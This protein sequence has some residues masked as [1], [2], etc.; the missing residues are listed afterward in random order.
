M[1]RRA[2][3]TLCALALA[4]TPPALARLPQTEPGHLR[5][6]VLRDVDN[7]NPLLSTQAASSDIAQLVFSGLIRYDDRGEA[8]PDAAEAVPTRRNGGIS[9]DG[10]T[11]TYHLRRNVV[12]SDG[13]PLTANDVVFTW[14]AVLNP[15]NNVPNHF[16]YDLAQSVVAKDRF[17]VVAHLREPNA[18]FV[19]FFMRCGTQGAILPEHLL[20]AKHDLNQDPYNRQPVGSGPFVVTSYQPGSSIELARNPRW[21]GAK[22]PALDR[23]S[24]R[25]IPNENSLLVA[26]RTHEIDF[27]FAAPEQ[28]YRELQALGGVHVSAQPFMSYEAVVF[29]TRRAPFDDVRVRRA[30]AAAIDWDA[31][32]RNVY[33]AVDLPGVTDVFPRSWAFDPSVKP[34]P[35][36]LARA[37]AFLDAAGWHPGSDGIRTRNGQRLTVTMRTVTGVI[38]R[39]NA[40]VQI[41]QQ[42]RL[43]GFDVQVVNAPAN[44]LFAPA[45]GGGV[46]AKGDFDAAI[47]GWTEAPDPADDEQTIGPDRVPPYGA[48]FSG[49]RDPEIG[50]LQREGASSYEPARR[51][52]A[53]VALQRREHEMVPFETIVW[54]ANIDAISD[55]FHGF[56]PAV[57]VSDFWNPWD[58]SI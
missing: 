16:P 43:V 22:K 21:W 41:Q 58:W 15:A 13:Q 46:L 47:Y 57:A 30:A 45:G 53:Y 12:F 11:I 32:A 31:L 28:Q 18:A 29:N 35:Y 25:F 56:R 27:Y 8:I 40:E 50:R 51:K 19:A 42:L 23:I 39:Q 34:Y 20:G 6:G 4:T 2:A 7:I 37:R 48:N 36:D 49:L 33:L 17:T 3:A 54:R 52:P 5:I 10:K 24:Y 26:L 9:A 1:V 44:L 55:D 38:P 14:R